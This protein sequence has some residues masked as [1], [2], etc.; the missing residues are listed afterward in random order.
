MR[1]ISIIKKAEKRRQ[2][3]KENE[4]KIRSIVNLDSN[5]SKN[6]TSSFVLRYQDFRIRSRNSKFRRVLALPSVSVSLDKTKPTVQ[7]YIEIKTSRNKIGK[8]RKEEETQET[9]AK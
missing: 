9:E 7:G 5:S 6:F 2:E 1:Y 8:E 3:N 4:A